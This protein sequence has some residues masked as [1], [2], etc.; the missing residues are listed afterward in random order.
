VKYHIER[1]RT[2][3]S[4]RIEAPGGDEQGLLDAVN[5]C[6]QSA[7]ACPS[8]ECLNIS[9]MGS[10]AADGNVYLTLTPRAGEQLDLA[11]IEECLRYTLHKAVKT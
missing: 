5:H 2:G 11:A 8:G 1:Q 3:I 6:R 10:S 4:I 7:W 9:T